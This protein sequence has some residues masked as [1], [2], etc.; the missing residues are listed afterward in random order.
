M[1]TWD[2]IVAI[3]EAEIPDVS[4]GIFERALIDLAEPDFARVTECIDAEK[5]YTTVA[6]TG[7]YE[8]PLGVVRIQRVEFKGIKLTATKVE[9]LLS[10]EQYWSDG[11]TLR[12]GRPRKYYTTNDRL[13]LI[14]VPTEAAGLRVWYPTLPTYATRKYIALTGTGTTTVYLEIG[15]PALAT[16][17]VT[18]T[19]ITR[20]L[21][22]NCSAYTLDGNRH[23]YTVAS[24]AAQAAGDIISLALHKYIPMIPEIHVQRLIPYALSKGYAS[25]RDRRNARI[26]MAEY[27]R[28]RDEVIG[29][30]NLRGYP[31]GVVHRNPVIR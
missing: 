13:H 2:E 3:C 23:K 11:T 21:T 29:E 9:N 15:I 25:I 20:S 16:D 14:P 30:R 26:E 31:D 4:P 10:R 28:L 8:L 27:E 6:S 17:T 7:D 12:T 18:F 1:L 5:A 19:N 22:G 24:M